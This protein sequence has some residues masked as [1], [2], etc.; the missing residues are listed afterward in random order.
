[1]SF[2]LKDPGA[3][4]DYAVDWGADYLDND[5]IA[6][7]RW[8]VVPAEPGGVLVLGAS[9]D[10]KVATV[11]AAGGTAGRQYRLTNHVVTA[12]GREDERSLVLRVEQR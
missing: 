9:F 2:L 7:S 11:T 5:V 3:T 10:D 1:M 6:E 8:A 4:L 12:S